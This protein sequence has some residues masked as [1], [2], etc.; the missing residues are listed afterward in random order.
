MIGSF[1]FWKHEITEAIDLDLLSQVLKSGNLDIGYCGKIRRFALVTLQRLSS[2][3]KEDEMKA[4]HQKLLKE[5]AET[6]QTQDE[7]KHPHIAAMIKGLRSVLE[8][9]QRLVK[10]E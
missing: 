2:P 1:N 6:C 5:L 9:I 3:A 10:Y 7:L 8:Q 4:L